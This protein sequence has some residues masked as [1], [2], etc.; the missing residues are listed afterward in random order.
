MKKVL[1]PHSDLRK[2]KPLLGF[3]YDGSIYHLLAFDFGDDGGAV[4]IWREGDN[5]CARITLDSLADFHNEAKAMH[6]ESRDSAAPQPNGA[7][8][9]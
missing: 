2:A 6:I 9:G 1:L 8:H 7:D 3:D 4:G 5:F